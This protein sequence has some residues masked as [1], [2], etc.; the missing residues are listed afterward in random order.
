ME[1]A[2]ARGQTRAISRTSPA[3]RGPVSNITAGPAAH[4]DRR[5][6][7]TVADEGVGFP[8]ELRDKICLPFFTTKRE[9]TG[10]GLALVSAVIR[11]HGGQLLIDSVPGHGSRFM[12]SLPVRSIES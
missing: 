10:L 6:E 5:W 11:S 7:L 9:G 3:L 12:I 2:I 4:S 1:F 8:D